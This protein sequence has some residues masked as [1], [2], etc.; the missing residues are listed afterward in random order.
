MA[1][2]ANTSHHKK[3]PSQASTIKYRTKEEYQFRYSSFFFFTETQS[4]RTSQPVRKS[5]SLKIYG[6]L[7]R[8][9]YRRVKKQHGSPRMT[10]NLRHTGCCL[11][12]LRGSVTTTKYTRSY[13]GHT[14]QKAIATRKY[15]N[16]RIIQ[17]LYHFFIMLHKMYYF[18]DNFA[19]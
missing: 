3:W 6:Y 1:E 14:T 18:Y 8:G 5:E 13:A 7:S 4:H 16:Q 10:K 9:A 17:F 19:K 12:T 15:R 2:L 11:S